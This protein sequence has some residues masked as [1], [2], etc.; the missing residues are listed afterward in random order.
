MRGTFKPALET[1]SSVANLVEQGFQDVEVAV[2]ADSSAGG[3][4]MSPDMRCL[5]ASSVG[6]EV[7]GR[8]ATPNSVASSAWQYAEPTQTLFFLDWDDTLFPCTELFERWAL[9]RRPGVRRG[10]S[11]AKSG[12]AVARQ[13]SQ[14]QVPAELE[15]DLERWREAVEEY[16]SVVCALSDRCVVVTNSS[17]PWV[18]SC[19]ER[20]APNL[21]RFFSGG[22]RGVRV[23][24]AGEALRQARA[25]QASMACCCC[26]QWWHTVQEALSPI[27]TSEDRRVELTSAKLSAMRRE[28]IIFYSR[29]P[30]QTW[31]NIISLGDMK[32]ERDA[33]Q[34]LSATRVSPARERLRTKAMVLPGAPTLEELT[35]WL[36]L[37]RVLLPVLA[38]FDG[39]V[40]LDL[41]CAADPLQ[42]LAKALGLP[43]LSHVSLPQLGPTWYAPADGPG[44]YRIVSE[45][46]VESSSSQGSHVGELAAGAVV[47]VAEVVTCVIHRRIRGRIA[48][49]PGWITLVGDNG[50]GR[51]AH[52]DVDDQLEEALDEVAVSVQESMFLSSPLLVCSSPLALPS[53][54][55]PPW[56]PPGLTL[57]A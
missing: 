42:K 10:G 27:P 9:P 6:S 46:Q 43:S 30:G 15:R 29:Y 36:R 40:D 39:N 51:S 53:G 35:L 49:P 24:Y 26:P 33:V 21:R 20:F 38:R 32:Y 47:E 22:A 19:I 28:A 34:E 5:R 25:S 57:A 13:T 3:C 17:P 54:V 11:A 2:G 14:E 7:M 8:M 44:T 55:C 48:N 56:P 16:L 52:K 37:F 31:K 41:H 1:I 50:C 4:T 12:K 45:V 23:V 18:E